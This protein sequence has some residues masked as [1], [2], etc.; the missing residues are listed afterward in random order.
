MARVR[1]SQQ[2]TNIRITWLAHGWKRVLDQQFIVKS[3]AST[4]C[5]EERKRRL[6]FTEKAIQSHI[7]RKIDVPLEQGM[8]N[9]DDDDDANNTDR[10]KIKKAGQ[11]CRGSR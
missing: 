10:I 11:R 6:I 3:H 1:L 5:L 8:D 4:A 7:K 2:H 9:D